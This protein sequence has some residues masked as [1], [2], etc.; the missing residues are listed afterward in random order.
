M[1]RFLAGHTS[2]P[3]AERIPAQWHLRCA[4]GVAWW[5]GEPPQTRQ[6]TYEPFLFIV[7]FCAACAILPILRHQFDQICERRAA[8]HQPA[9]L[10]GLLCFVQPESQE[11]VKDQ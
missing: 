4:C 2:P 1:A 10:L 5:G 6:T 3:L 11:N 9:L 8:M 7:L